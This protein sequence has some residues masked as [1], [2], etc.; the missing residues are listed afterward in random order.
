MHL[1]LRS[2]FL[3]LLPMSNVVNFP[4]SDVAIFMAGL[5]VLHMNGVKFRLKGVRA[6]AEGGPHNTNSRAA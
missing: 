2:I 5:H 3:S 1:N 4:T 6:I